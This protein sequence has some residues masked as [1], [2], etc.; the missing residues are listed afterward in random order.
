M[1]YKKLV[2]SLGTLGI[3]KQYLNQITSSGIFS[4]ER[5]WGDMNPT[6][7][8]I[9]YSKTMS[10]VRKEIQTTVETCDFG[11]SRG[12]KFLRVDSL[13]RGT[14]SE[15]I[16]MGSIIYV[17]VNEVLVKSGKVDFLT[18]KR[19]IVRYKLLSRAPFSDSA[20]DAFYTCEAREDDNDIYNDSYFAERDRELEDEMVGSHNDPDFFDEDDDY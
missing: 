9:D 18:K 4:I 15:A 1:K 19:D 10:Y 14:L 6:K 17:G 12:E 20:L 16:D 13:H 2:L 5:A 3:V 7:K 11:P 8:G